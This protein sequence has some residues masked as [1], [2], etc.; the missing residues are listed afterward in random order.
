M[1][2]V[3]CI[4]SDLPVVSVKTSK[5]I[6]LSMMKKA[7]EALSDINVKAPVKIGDIIT[8]DFLGTGVEVVATRLCREERSMQ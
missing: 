5:P 3:K 2:V 6:H 7:S 8:N 4:G 1:S